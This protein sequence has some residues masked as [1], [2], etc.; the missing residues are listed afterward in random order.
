MALL[1]TQTLLGAWNYAMAARDEVREEAWAEFLDTLHRV[2]R[3][4]TPEI[5]NGIAF[6]RE[7][8][9]CASGD[10]R[11]AHPE[12]EEGIRKA[13]EI[14]RGGVFQ[15]RLSRP[16]RVDGEEILLYGVLDVLKCGIIYDVKFSNRAFGSAEL[17]G[18]YLESPQ[19][20]TYLYLAPE[21]REFTYLVSDGTD[22]YTETYDARGTRHVGELAS[23]FLGFLRAAGLTDA[24]REKWAARK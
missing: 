19:H 15:V 5:E 1:M 20:P 17:A 22:L 16:L 4:S 14:V 11:D 23:E 3:P 9:R 24:Y 18:K 13:A 10:V 6:E 8:Y 12:W 21:A 7:V 2:P